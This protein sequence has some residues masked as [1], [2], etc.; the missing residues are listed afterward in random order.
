MIVWV[1]FSTAMFTL[2]A[3]P[4]LALFLSLA[5]NT[6]ALDPLAHALGVPRLFYVIDVALQELGYGVNSLGAANPAADKVTVLVD[7]HHGHLIDHGFRL[8]E[9]LDIDASARPLLQ[10]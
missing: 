7:D 6:F 2:K 1:A 3:L 5:Q 10:G 4:A 8:H 9:C